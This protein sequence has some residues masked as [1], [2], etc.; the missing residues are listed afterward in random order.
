M[1]GTSKVSTDGRVRR[2]AV[3]RRTILA[4]TRELIL[5]GTLD[6][7]AREIAARAGITTRTLFRH[8]PDMESLHRSFVEDANAGATSVMDEPFPQAAQARWQDLLAVVIERRV[9]VYE[10]LLPLYV[11]TIWSRHHAT[12]ARQDRAVVRRRKRLKDILPGGL[13]EVPALFEAL[14]GVLSIEYWKSLRRD[15]GL[16]VAEATAV[17]RIAV[18]KLTAEIES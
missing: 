3:T 17:L 9:R 4:A 12:A 6:P 8:F 11:S 16:D 14:D 1:S 10:S 5:E 15:Q 7:T 13:T 18:D 2:T